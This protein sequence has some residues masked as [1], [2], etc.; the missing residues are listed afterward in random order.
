MFNWTCWECGYNDLLGVGLEFAHVKPTKLSGQGRGFYA[1]YRDVLK[2][3]DCY[4][5]M[6]CDCHKRF[7]RGF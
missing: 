6:C 4:R 1:R 5:L 7:D 3:P 2:N